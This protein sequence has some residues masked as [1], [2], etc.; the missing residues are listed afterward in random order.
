VVDA[1]RTRR[2]F[3]ALSRSRT[4][5][6]SGP[7]WV[8]RADPPADVPESAGDPV[9]VAYAVGRAV[10]GAVARNRLRRRLRVL[11]GDLDAAGAL[12]PGL[13]LVGA[14]SSATTA[15]PDDLRRH[16]AG[17]LDRAR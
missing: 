13:Y 10:G 2:A 11:V 17:A 3:S 4:R 5:G 12:S 1:V 14:G 7:L 8:V 16:L 15:T 9:R 6:R